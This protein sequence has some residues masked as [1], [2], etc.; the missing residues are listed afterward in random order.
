MKMKKR[1]LPALVLSAFAAFGAT[2]AQSS[3]FSAVY[4][5]G[6][7]LSDAGYYRGFLLGVGLPRRRWLPWDGSRR[8]RGFP[9]WS[10]SPSSTA[11]PPC[12]AT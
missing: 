7:S 1:I 3:Q 4:A 6:D 5:F 11:C 10:T 8:I 9:G 2:E 12:P